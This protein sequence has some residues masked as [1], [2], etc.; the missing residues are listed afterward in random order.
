MFVCLGCLSNAV[1][2]MAPPFFTICT[3]HRYGKLCVC[4]YLLWMWI[5]FNINSLDRRNQLKVHTTDIFHHSLQW[6]VIVHSSK[7]FQILYIDHKYFL[8]IKISAFHFYSSYSEWKFNGM[9][10]SLLRNSQSPR[11]I[12][13]L[14][15]ELFG[16]I[17]IVF[18]H[19]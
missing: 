17:H 6:N 12:F 10:S 8:R 11:T 5:D 16:I 2:W 1:E 15:F 14:L 9:Q 7:S 19:K 18:S 3:A 4:V 13:I